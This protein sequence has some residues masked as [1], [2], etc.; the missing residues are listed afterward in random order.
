MTIHTFK[1]D[2]PPP[3]ISIG[4][5]GWLR[6]NLFSS[7]INTLLTRVGLYPVR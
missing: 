6:A 2:L 4:S 7:W 1:P 5:L 3:T